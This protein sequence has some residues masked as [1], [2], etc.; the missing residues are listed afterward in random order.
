MIFLVHISLL[1]LSWYH[2]LWTWLLR[3]LIW[4]EL[5]NKI[6]PYRTVSLDSCL[7]PPSVCLVAHSL[8]F[9]P[10]ILWFKGNFISMAAQQLATR[11]LSLSSL[12]GRAGGV[13]TGKT[14]TRAPSQLHAPLRKHPWLECHSSKEM[15]LVPP[16]YIPKAGWRNKSLTVNS[17]FAFSS[18][19]HSGHEWKKIIELSI[20][21][22][23]GVCIQNAFI[24]FYFFNDLIC[25]F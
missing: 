25:F 18:F 7:P 8:F 2:F 5:S 20:P 12:P 9:G 6:K 1:D 3:S 14:M 10:K 17:S 15:T 11:S 22:F 4:E 21:T 19:W 13:G 24:L 16:F 23:L